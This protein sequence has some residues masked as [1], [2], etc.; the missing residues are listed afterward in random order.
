MTN[1]SGELTEKEIIQRVQKG[2]K[3]LYSVLVK[4]YNAYLYKVGRS[5]NFNHAD[6]EDL[7]Q[8]TYIDAFK[9]LSQFES[10]S[11]FKTWIIRIM[12]HNCYRKK[13][14]LSYK[15]EIDQEP[16]ENDTPMFAS[17][18]NNTNRI[19]QNHE[20]HNTIENALLKIPLDYRMVFTLREVNGINVA[21][22]AHLL[23][24]S[25]AN[26]KV[27]LNRAKT[28]LQV[29]INK[30]YSAEEIFEFNLIHCHPLTEGVMKNVHSL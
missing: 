29:E 15:N 4:R 1:A 23:N 19:I 21:E 3:Q 28:L 26:V 7:M 22:T 18:N 17:D 2:E 5:Y 25:E 14:R 30:A 13:T 8:E 11:S 27:R 10:R 12:I 9:N 16:E 6:T 20:L 24:I